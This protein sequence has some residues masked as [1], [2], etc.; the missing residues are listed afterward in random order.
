MVLQGKAPYATSES[1]ALYH[2]FSYVI[3]SKISIE[4]WRNSIKSLL[5]PA[6]LT[7]FSEINNETDPNYISNVSINSTGDSEIL[8]YSTVTIDSTLGPFNV[9]NVTYIKITGIAGNSYLTVDTTFLQT[10]PQ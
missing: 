4:N 1:L 5:H 10:N 8:T 3:R 2:P 7:A 6:G 9:S